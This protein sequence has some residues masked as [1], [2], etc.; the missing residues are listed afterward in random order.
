MKKDWIVVQLYLLFY[1]IIN[2]IL[3]PLAKMFIKAGDEDLASHI[4]HNWYWMNEWIALNW[5]SIVKCQVINY[6]AISCR[7]QVWWDDDDVHVVLDQ[8][9]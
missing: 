4:D 8:H 6:S 2:G 7:D 9:A 3:F 5:A 1:Y